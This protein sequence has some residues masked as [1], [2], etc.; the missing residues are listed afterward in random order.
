[1]KNKMGTSTHNRERNIC[2][3]MRREMSLHLSIRGD[4][5]EKKNL[6]TSKLKKETSPSPLSHSTS[7]L[8][9]NEKK[10][11]QIEKKNETRDTKVKYN[12]INS[13]VNS[14]ITR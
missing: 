14:C 10:V 3:N 8:I 12:T 5:N 11:I 6:I 1:M 4:I 7:H 13:K 9:S 2:N